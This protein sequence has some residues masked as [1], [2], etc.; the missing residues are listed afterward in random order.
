MYIVAIAQPHVFD[1]IKKAIK[2]SWNCDDLIGLV[3]II[4]DIG[5]VRKYI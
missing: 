4:W 5:V 1:F 2:L 3:I